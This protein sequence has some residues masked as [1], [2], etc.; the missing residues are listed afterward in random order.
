MKFVD[1]RY[2]RQASKPAQGQKPGFEGL[3]KGTVFA[4]SFFMDLL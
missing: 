1:V 3:F 2:Q 4:R